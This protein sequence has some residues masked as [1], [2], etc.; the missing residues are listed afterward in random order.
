[1][2]SFR[3]VVY[4]I[5]AALLMCSAAQAGSRE[6]FINHLHHIRATDEVKLHPMLRAIVNGRQDV[7]SR[8]N[9][10]R[11]LPQFS[12]PDVAVNVVA[13]GDANALASQLK[14]LGLTHAKVYGSM[15]SGRVAIASLNAMAAL[16]GVHSVRPALATTHAGLV[17]SQGDRAQFSGFARN[18]FNVDGRG[19]TVGVLSDSFSCLTGPIFDGQMFT[20]M[21]Q[22]I[23]NGD[24]PA[25]VRILSDAADC[26]SSHDEGRAIAQIIHD[27]A[28]GAAILYHSAFNGEA[29]FAQGI[30]DLANAGADIIVDDVGYFDE[31][32]FQDGIVAQAVD[33]VKKRGVAY[34]SSAG[35]SARASYESAFRNSGVMGVSGVRHNFGTSKKPDPMQTITLTA[36]AIEAVFLNWDEPFKSAGGKGSRSDVDLIY[37]DMDGNPIPPCDVNLQPAVCQ[38]AGVNSN[39]GG[40]AFEEGDILNTSDQD[41]QVQVSIELYQGPAPHYLKY[42]YFDFGGGT[43]LVDEYDTQSGASYG[44]PIAAGAEAVGAAAWYNTAAWNSALHPGQCY[45]ACLEYFSS[46]G[47]VP[48]FFDKKGNRLRFPEQ[49]RKPEVVGPDGGN[50]TFFYSLF[51]YTVPGSTEPDAFPNFFGTSAS[52]PHVAAIAALM[53]D[54]HRRRTGRT[55][56]PDRIYRTLEL[57]ASD[58]HLAAGRA[59]APYP[60]PFGSSGFDFDSG[61]GY[62]NAVAALAATL[63]W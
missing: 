31:P 21:A 5:G 24:L 16:P 1:M 40:D 20:T 19:V 25:N 10:A 62:V 49:R 60:F 22:D 58:M 63:F 34:F 59:L 55:A 61:Y 56:S 28:P 9:L 23:A 27:V 29:D 52:A 4:G 44:H 30:I 14:S 39:I 54:K 26:S 36:G 7:G 57:T 37:Y 42:V 50:T 17:T 11:R 45:P 8:E 46:A 51:N 3:S 35:N 18:L 15:V 53:I 32:M 13:N 6:D 43:M 2:G 47:G 41:V 38:F 48:T 12:H 33:T